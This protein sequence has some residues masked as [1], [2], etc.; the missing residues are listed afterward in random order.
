VAVVNYQLFMARRK[1]ENLSDLLLMAPW[2]VSVIFGGISFVLLRGV[3]PLIFETN[4]MLVLFIPTLQMLSPFV[5]IFFIFV[6]M[7]AAF[8]GHRVGKLVDRQT[9]LQS[10]QNISW[11]EF[12]WMV[13]EAFRRQGYSVTESLNKGPDGG[14]D[15][16]LHKDG[17][18]SL[19]Q[20]K[21]WK[22]YSV[23]APVV[24]EIFGL[25]IDHKADEAIVVTSGKFT[26][27]AVQFSE[28]KP[29]TLVDG[30]Q[31]LN[32]VSSVQTGNSVKR[33]SYPVPTRIPNCPKCGAEMALRIARKGRNSGNK[34]WGC[35]RFPKCRGTL[36]LSPGSRA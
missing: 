18:K 1:E 12:E 19:V 30:D 29:I 27:E 4:S 21:R 32:L 2:W 17:K 22:T 3:L 15:L 25:L 14:V 11:K 20:C 26:S 13:A 23:G 34:F 24:R 33:A 6:A 31:L 35:S 10:L 7:M 9:S 8:R 5:L 16:V 36:A 28:G